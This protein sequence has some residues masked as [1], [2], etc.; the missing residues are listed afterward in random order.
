MENLNS[1]DSILSA[2]EKMA[3][4]KEPVDAHTWLDGVAK[5][6]ALIGN[7]QN[8]LFELE[9]ELAKIK[10]LAMESGDSVSK[11]KVR[12]E[13]TETSLEVNKLKAKINRA[14]EIC[15]VGKLMARMSM[16]EMRQQV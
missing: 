10:M 9:N 16:E 5:L 6:L 3:S 8:K 15:R 7:E 1:V 2:L 11:A 4:T 13:A 12:A 14:F